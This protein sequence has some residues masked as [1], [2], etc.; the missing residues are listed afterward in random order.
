MLPIYYHHHIGDYCATCSGIDYKE[1]FYYK[2]YCDYSKVFCSPKCEEEYF[3]KNPSDL[4]KPYIVYVTEKD[5]YTYFFNMWSLSADCA[6]EMV[7]WYFPWIEDIEI[8]DS[9]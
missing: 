5:G 3:T 4:F 2:E 7:K 6:R 8:Q 1:S 9:V